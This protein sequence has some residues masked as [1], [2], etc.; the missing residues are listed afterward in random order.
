[1]WNKFRDWYIA[2]IGLCLIAGGLVIAARHPSDGGAKTGDTTRS[3]ALS[4]APEAMNPPTAPSGWGA[5][6]RAH[7]AGGQPRAASSPAA[8]DS[9][10]PPQAAQNAAPSTNQRIA[11]DKP[12]TAPAPAAAPPS[13]SGPAPIAGGDAV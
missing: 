7:C 12:A 9:P 3:A 8:S 13:Q 10:A 4:S 1:M 5:Q 2:G 11:Q 6:A